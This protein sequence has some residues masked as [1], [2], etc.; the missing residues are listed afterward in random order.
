MKPDRTEELLRIEGLRVERGETTVLDGVDW[1]VRR[2]EH[3]VVLGANGCGKTSLLKVLLGYLT[4]SAGAVRVLGRDYGAYDWRE[5]RRRLGLVSSALHGSVPEHE[6]ALSTVASGARAQLDLWGEPTP[7]EARAARRQLARAGAAALAER[8]WGVLSQGERQRVL[9][10]R[11]LMARP[12]LLILDE[13]CAGLD[14]LAREEFLR[15]MEALAREP[16]GPG[17]VLVTHHVEE[18]TPAFSHALLLRAGRVVAAGPRAA[19]LTAARLGGVFATRIQLRRRGRGATT[20][21][22][23]RV[24]R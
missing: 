1:R 19:T 10:A 7:A 13:P 17:L 18:I 5:L 22:E 16:R 4:P 11:A 9:I 20:R 8:R 3:W 14:P 21:L 24:G 2:G 15:R 23:L 12:R 6:P